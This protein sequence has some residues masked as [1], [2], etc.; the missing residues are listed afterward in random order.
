MSRVIAFA[1]LAR[2]DSRGAHFREDFPAAGPLA[3][4]TYTVARQSGKD[5]VIA[6]EPVRFARLTPA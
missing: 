6:H 1:A 3:R 5:V 2:Q 4:S